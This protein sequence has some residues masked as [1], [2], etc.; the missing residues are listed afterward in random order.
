MTVALIGIWIPHSSHGYCTCDCTPVTCFE[1][2]R[3]A[4]NC[5]AISSSLTSTSHETFV[6]AT[7]ALSCSTVERFSFTAVSS[8]REISNLEHFTM[9][10]SLRRIFRWRLCILSGVSFD[11]G[12]WRSCSMC[13]RHFGDSNLLHIERCGLCLNN[14]LGN[15][16]RLVLFCNGS[17]A[18]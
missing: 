12:F 5:N 1:V 9:S 18:V 2:L 7:Y 13:V 11:W 15:R 3:P 14:K 17:C 4:C 10:V 16:S 8:A 6:L